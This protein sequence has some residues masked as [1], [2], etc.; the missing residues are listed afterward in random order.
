MTPQDVREVDVREPHPSARHHE[1]RAGVVARDLGHA[2]VGVGDD[3]ASE[4]EEAREESGHG[5]PRG[6]Y[7]GGEA[8]G[9]GGVHGDEVDVEGTEYEVEVGRLEHRGEVR[10]RVGR[11]QQRP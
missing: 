4:R 9:R 3:A 7:H 11:P 10:R 6:S 2:G 1:L 5:G 8:R